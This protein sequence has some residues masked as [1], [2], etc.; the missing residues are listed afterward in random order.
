[1]STSKNITI[2]FLLTSLPQWCIADD[3]TDNILHQLRKEAKEEQEAYDY[4]RREKVRQWFSKF[5][6]SHG[7]YVAVRAGSNCGIFPCDPIDLE[8]TGGP[9]TFRKNHGATGII[10]RTYSLAGK[11]YYTVTWESGRICSGDFDISGGEKEV[12]L[13][14]FPSC[15][16]AGSYILW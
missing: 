9:G 16:E 4:Q 3:N 8:I 15:R 14:F 6:S 10:H 13:S 1:M 12:N 2:F 7:N 5:G 11:Y